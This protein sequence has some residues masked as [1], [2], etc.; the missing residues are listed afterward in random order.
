MFAGRLKCSS[1]PLRFPYQLSVGTLAFL[2]C[3]NVKSFRVHHRVLISNEP[4]VLPSSSSCD[5]R[6]TKSQQLPLRKSPRDRWTLRRVTSPSLKA[7]LHVRRKHKNKHKRKDQTRVNWDD[8][9]TSTSAR[10]SLLPLCLRRPGSHV[11]Y[12]CAC[13]VRATSLKGLVELRTGCCCRSCRI[14]RIFTVPD[15]NSVREDQ[16][17]RQYLARCCVWAYPGFHLIHLRVGNAG[18]EICRY[19]DSREPGS[20]LSWRK[21]FDAL[22]Y[23]PNSFTLI[24]ANRVMNF[25]ADSVEDMNSWVQGTCLRLFVSRGINGFSAVW[26]EPKNLDM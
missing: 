7:G 3:Q 21:V 8:A 4:Q 15:I 26:F 5:Q 13:V 22:C 14:V 19:G 25:I 1:R 23:R 17:Q 10:S 24:T 12:A 18:A 16:A 2:S 11:A 6:W 9:S 20:F